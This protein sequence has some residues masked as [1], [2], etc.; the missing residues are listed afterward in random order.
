M[1]RDLLDERRIAEKLMLRIRKFIPFRDDCW[2]LLCDFYRE[3]YGVELPRYEYSSIKQEKPPDEVWRDWRIIDRVETRPGDA[4]LLYTD[5][6]MHLGIIL[7]D[8]DFIHS[9]CMGN[10]P[11]RIGRLTDVS[12][13]IPTSFARYRAFDNR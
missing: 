2:T 7:D 3:C 13:D 1:P 9:T 6:G 8:G 5:M 11:V 4:I 12:E 10:P